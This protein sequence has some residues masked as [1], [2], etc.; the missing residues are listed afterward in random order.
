[1]PV[2]FPVEVAFVAFVAAVGAFLLYRTE[3]MWLR[4]L[5]QGLQHPH[6]AW[7]KRLLLKG[8][9][10]VAAATLYVEKQVRL[11]LSHFAAGGLHM[12]SRVFSALA[13]AFHFT[14]REL[15]L[16]AH[17]VADALAYLRHHTI[18]HLI[19]AAVT[20]VDRLAH[21]A[22]AE[23]L[24]ADRFAHE[25][26]KRFLR[27]IDRLAHRIDH[28][29]IPRV[30]AVE[31]KLAGVISR[32]LPAIRRR[33]A[34]LEHEVYGDLR[35]RIGRI[36]RALGLGVFAA[37][38]Y[39]I[40]AKVAPWLFCRNVSTVGRAVCGLNPNQ[41]NALLGLLLGTL[42]IRD[43]RTLARYAEAVERELA[44]EVRRLTSAF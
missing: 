39:K 31:G 26:L 34:A 29:V 44:E 28:I 7:W 4:P 15:G 9:A 35:A 8:A 38:V 42:A 37:L 22:Y 20:P 41:L 6:G 11:A 10:G 24:A 36:E 43:I 16:I 19:H 32:D 1:M 40:L 30:R 21:K 13:A 17:D 2:V 25:L 27:G 18:P 23:A 33:E 12:L 5:V 3:V 14:Y